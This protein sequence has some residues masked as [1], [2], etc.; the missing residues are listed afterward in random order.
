[1]RASKHL[2][3]SDWSTYNEKA[4]LSHVMQEEQFW[5]TATSPASPRQ[6]TVSIPCTPRPPMLTYCVERITSLSEWCCARRERESSPR[7]RYLNI[8]SLQAYPYLHR[9]LRVL[10]CVCVLKECSVSSALFCLVWRGVGNKQGSSRRTNEHLWDSVMI[11]GHISDAVSANQLASM[12]S[13]VA[14]TGHPSGVS[15]N[16]SGLSASGP[17]PTTIPGSSPMLPTFHFTQE[18]VACVC[19]VLQQSGS[20]ERLARFLWSLPPCEPLQK[21][22]SVLKAKA[23]VAF[24]RWVGLSRRERERESITRH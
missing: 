5:V 24:H 19:E 3:Q 10:P 18:Q 9:V 2:Y 12:T 13:A 1:M 11:M 14:L 21:N 20:I 4:C 6:T 8:E 22:E 17:C 15:N 23:I 7:E 16:S